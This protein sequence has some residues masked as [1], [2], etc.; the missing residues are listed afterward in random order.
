MGNSGDHP[1]LVS[2]WS[3]FGLERSSLFETVECILG[4]IEGQVVEEI[5]DK[6][7]STKGILPSFPYFNPPQISLTSDPDPNPLFLR[8]FPVGLVLKI[9]VRVSPG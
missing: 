6:T 3:S 5:P 8:W 2:F 9:W 7:T 1:V 4:S